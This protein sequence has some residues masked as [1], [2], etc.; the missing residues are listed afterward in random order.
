M[1]IHEIITESTEL[2]EGWKS[3][4]GAAA[5]A[6]AAAF[7]GGH[8]DADTIVRRSDGSTVNYSTNEYTPSTRTMAQQRQI[9]AVA[10]QKAEQE[11]A[12]RAAKQSASEITFTSQA[13]KVI[14]FK[15]TH[16]KYFPVTKEVVQSYGD[17]GLQV[18]RRAY[19][20]IS[21]EETKI[22]VSDGTNQGTYDDL[23]NDFYDNITAYKS[24]M[25]DPSTW[26]K[27]DPIVV[28][29]MGSQEP[30]A[31]QMEKN[32]AA[33]AGDVPIAPWLKKY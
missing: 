1:R 5:L 30:S 2:E 21:A 7:G 28:N 15:K 29:Q 18:L 9:D 24:F 6:G 20:D 16:A 14:N 10:K 19:N 22:K 17:P 3:K 13:N 23:M 32:R 26:A 8:A 25:A 12:A 11:A 33:M 31:A 27:F 4:L